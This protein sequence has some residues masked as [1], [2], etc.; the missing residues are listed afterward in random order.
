MER[1]KPLQSI[2]LQGVGLMLKALAALASLVLQ[3]FFFL[4]LLM[5]IGDRGRTGKDR[6]GK[7][8]GGHP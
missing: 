6:E 5:A 4:L 1:K 2:F 7:P 8:A 3:V